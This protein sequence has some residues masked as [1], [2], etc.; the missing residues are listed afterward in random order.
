MEDDSRVYEVGKKT[1]RYEEDQPVVSAQGSSLH[2]FYRP[3]GESESS[4]TSDT[5]SRE[6]GDSG[7]CSQDETET[8]GTSFRPD[9]P[10]QKP[11]PETAVCVVSLS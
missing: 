7:N 11:S 5:G 10:V 8:S 6:T 4:Q 1:L 2:I 3:L 9:D